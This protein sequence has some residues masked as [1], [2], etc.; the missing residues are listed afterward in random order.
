MCVRTDAATRV[1]DDEN[2]SNDDSVRCT[3]TVQVL[4]WE[5]FACTEP[6][7][8]ELFARA[9]RPS[10]WKQPIPATHETKRGVTDCVWSRGA[11]GRGGEGSQEYERSHSARVGSECVTTNSFFSSSTGSGIGRGGEAVIIT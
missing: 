2:R 10:P 7:Y 11:L 6:A 9:R 5:A 3:F 8:R 1:V 4:A